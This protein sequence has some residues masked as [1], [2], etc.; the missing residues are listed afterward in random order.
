VESHYFVSI[1]VHRLHA[2]TLQTLGRSIAVN[3]T[4]ATAHGLITPTPS[5][6]QSVKLHLFRV[7]IQKHNYH[8]LIQISKSGM[9]KRNMNRVTKSNPKVLKHI[10]C[11]YM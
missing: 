9:I 1:W 2:V 5:V 7:F 10:T 3:H 8:H 4:M 11:L 6:T